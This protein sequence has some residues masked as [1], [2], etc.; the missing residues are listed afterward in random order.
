MSIRGDGD[1]MADIARSFDS[2]SMRVLGLPTKCD[3]DVFRKPWWRARSPV[4]PTRVGPNATR[5]QD[6]DG[7]SGQ[8]T[9]YLEV[10][11]IEASVSQA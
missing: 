11:Y 10:E 1:W 6:W 7:G 3:C 8:L 5:E 9:V 2:R 4:G